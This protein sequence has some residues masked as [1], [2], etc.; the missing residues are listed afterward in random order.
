MYYLK[1][2]KSTKMAGLSAEAFPIIYAL[3]YPQTVQ[4][5]SEGPIVSI[6]SILTAILVLL[7]SLKHVSLFL[8]S[9]VLCFRPGAL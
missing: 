8:A 9:I 2:F 3:L 4:P 6:L 5:L 1:A 7:H